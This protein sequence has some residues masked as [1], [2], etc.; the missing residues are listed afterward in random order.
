MLQFALDWI[1]S[2]Q[3]YKI[4]MLDVSLLVTQG[5]KIVPIPVKIIAFLYL[6]KTIVKITTA[7]HEHYFFASGLGE[8]E[9]ILDPSLI[10]KANGQFIINKRAVV[11]AEHYLSRWFTVKLVVATPESIVISKAKSTEF[12]QLMEQ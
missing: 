7:S 5:D 4:L 2:S 1:F 9:Y 11:N 10:Y 6:D 3:F 8:V 12:L